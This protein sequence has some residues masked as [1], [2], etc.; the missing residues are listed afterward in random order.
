MSDQRAHQHHLNRQALRKTDQREF[1]SSIM[2]HHIRM[3]RLRE[4]NPNNSTAVTRSE[5]PPPPYSSTMTTPPTSPSPPVVEG[6][7]NSNRLN[8]QLA[9]EHI[10]AIETELQEMERRIHAYLYCTNAQISIMLIL[11]TLLFIVIIITWP[12]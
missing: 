5:T 12:F 6:R 3:W 4:S 2:H 7:N 8:G 11:C 10:V 1:Q 9:Y